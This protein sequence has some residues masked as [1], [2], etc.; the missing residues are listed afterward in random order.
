MTEETARKD[1]LFPLVRDFFERDP[2]SAT[3]TVEAMEDEE[4]IEVLKGLPL[5]LSV[6]AFRYLQTGLAADLLQQL[7]FSLSRQ[8]VEK[9]SAQRGATIL[10]HV[11]SEFRQKL[12]SRLA[13][14]RRAEIEEILAYPEGS[15]GRIMTTDFLAFPSDM[16]VRDAIQRIRS[17]AKKKVPASYVYVVDAEHRLVGVM[18]MR[19]LML[20]QENDPLEA[21][22]Q[23]EVFKVHAFMDREEIA[24]A[25][26]DRNY[27]AAP[28]VDREGY[29]LGVVHTDE[30]IEHVQEEASEDLQKM[31]GAGGDE[32][33]FSPIGF[34]LRKRLPWLHVNLATALIAASVISLFEGLI[35]KITILAVFL[36]VVAGQGGNAGAQSLALV[37]RGLVMRE[38][39]PH[40]VQRFVLKEGGI[41]LMNGLIVGGVAAAVTWIWNGNPFLGLV[42]GLAMV[43]NLVVAG[44]SG[45]L[46]PIAM[47][48]MGLDP[49]QSSSI[50]LTTV[51]DIVGFFSFLGLALLF[52]SYLIG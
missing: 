9:L 16:K 27:L 41:G 39:P 52:Q 47:K 11:P 40:K 19:D 10:L 28:V 13:T 8:I 50:I 46:I 26:S 51:T 49:A 36:P 30:L 21:V 12:L 5:S 1:P 2:V 29:L 23:K 6:E 44:L 7:P 45:A 17:I 34:S 3:Q 35:A 42:I 22:M 18:N 14:K 24:N 43:V 48:Q 31:V 38:I 32:W 20:A 25:L 15:A 37:I 4:A 33:P